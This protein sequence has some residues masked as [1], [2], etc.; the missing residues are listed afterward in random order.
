MAS[1]Q[2]VNPKRQQELQLQY[3]NYKNTLQQMAQKIGDIEQEAEE[4]KLVIET[5][6]PLPEERKCFRMVN[7]VLVERTIK[8]VLPTLKTNSDGLKQVLEELL[9][10]YKSK[11]TELDNWKKKNNIQVVQ[12]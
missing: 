10:Q 3:S 11:Q 6:E 4:H 8:D 2:Q 9:K 1:Q 12:P 5:L 7:G